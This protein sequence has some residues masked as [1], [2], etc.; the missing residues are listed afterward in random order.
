MEQ[1]QVTDLLPLIAFLRD[2]W[3][4]EVYGSFTFTTADG[5]IT[6]TLKATCRQLR[7]K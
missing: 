7:K 3:Q 4:N 1:K 5:I 6:A 2:D